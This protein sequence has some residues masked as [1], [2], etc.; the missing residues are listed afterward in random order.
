MVGYI[1]DTLFVLERK[2][3]L[4]AGIMILECYKIVVDVH[5]RDLSEK[6]LFS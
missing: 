4:A 2:V 5:L 1:T 3:H 6:L